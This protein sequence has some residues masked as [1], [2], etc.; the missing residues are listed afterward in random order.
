M[1]GIAVVHFFRGL[2][3]HCR[4]HHCT[5]ALMHDLG[6]VVMWQQARDVYR[7]VLER[8]KRERSGLGQ[9]GR[10]AESCT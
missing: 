9:W 2:P 6:I 3:R 1:A 4:M 7:A 5:A 10:A 8:A